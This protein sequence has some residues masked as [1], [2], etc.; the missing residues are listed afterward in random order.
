MPKHRLS[1]HQSRKGHVGQDGDDGE[2]IDG[3]KGDALAPGEID[4]HQAV[5]ETRGRENIGEPPCCLKDPEQVLHRSGVLDGG[6]AAVE[7]DHEGNQK[8]VQRQQ[9]IPVVLD[10]PLAV[11]Q[12]DQDGLVQGGGPGDQCQEV[13]GEGEVLHGSMPPGAPPHQGR[14]PP[15][16]SGSG[17]GPQR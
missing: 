1:D 17:Q 13:E 8:Q 4:T 5:I 6:D 15:C 11:A 3:E 9:K 12:V 7:L 10:G 2:D 16:R 14:E